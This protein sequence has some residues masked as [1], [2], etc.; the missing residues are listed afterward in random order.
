MS[1][2]VL[3]NN[4]FRAR[5][6]PSSGARDYTA[7][8]ARGV[9]FL[10]AGSRKVRCRAAGYAFGIIIIIIIIIIFIQLQLGFHPVAVV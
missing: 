5:L 3:L 4:M 7:S 6:C 1:H 10:V 2:N 9:W 8:I